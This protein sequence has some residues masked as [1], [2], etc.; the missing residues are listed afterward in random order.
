MACENELAIWLTWEREVGL[1]TGRLERS[2]AAVLRTGQELTTAQQNAA[3][4][5]TLRNE[6]QDALDAAT[7]TRDQARQAYETCVGSQSVSI[8]MVKL[9]KKKPKR[10]RR[11]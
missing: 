1:A 9:G 2:E 7:A 5:I 4:A 6:D 8:Q 11:K 3:D 10:K